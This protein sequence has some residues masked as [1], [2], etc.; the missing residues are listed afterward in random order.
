MIIQD[1]NSVLC[2]VHGFLPYLYVQAP[3]GFLDDDIPEF[4][5][6]L[7]RDMNDIGAIVKVEIVQKSNIYSYR[8]DAKV[9]FLKI[10]VSSHNAI[11]GAK[12][13]LEGS[14]SFSRFSN[15]TFQTFESNLPFIMR[16]MIDRKLT[17]MNWVECNKFTIRRN[18]HT[19]CQIEIDTLV[20]DLVSYAPEGEWQKLAPL[21]ILSFDIECSG[22]KGVFPDHNIDPVIQIASMVTLHG[23]SKPFIRCVFTLKSCANIVGS[24]VYS[25][26]NE[27]DLLQAWSEFFIQVDPDVIT[28]YNIGNFDWPY[29]IGRADK[30]K[31]ENFSYLGRISSEKV[32]SKLI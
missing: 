25:F 2:H 10:T 17:G 23:D 26:E 8:G 31:V 3:N 13:V 24:Q 21:R 27:R 9:P 15:M 18:K 14:F 6:S 19:P 7:E 12:R 30:L 22:R 20:D 32:N 4:L 29:L 1:Q 28:G 11:N 5:T 16:F